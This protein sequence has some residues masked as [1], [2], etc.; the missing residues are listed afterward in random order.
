MILIWIMY[1]S[2]IIS[3]SGQWQWAVDGM[4]DSD[5]VKRSNTNVCL[6]WG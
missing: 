3:G 2:I 1:R 4:Y 6:C 5:I